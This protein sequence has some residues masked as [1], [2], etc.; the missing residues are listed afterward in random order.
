MGCSAESRSTRRR[1]QRGN[2]TLALKP[3]CKPSGGTSTAS[4]SCRVEDDRPSDADTGTAHRSTQAEGGVKRWL[5]ELF[6]AAERR[7]ADGLWSLGDMIGGGPDPERAVAVTRQHCTV[8]LLRNHDYGAT[9][10]V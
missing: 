5:S 6:R 7:G 9:G 3:S 1:E 8:A 10:A 2:F 4:N